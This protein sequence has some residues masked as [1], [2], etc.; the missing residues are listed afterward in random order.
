MKMSV[1]SVWGSCL[2]LVPS[3]ANS[4]RINIKSDDL[5]S[6]LF[7]FGQFPGV[8]EKS[9]QY[10]LFYFQLEDGIQ[11]LEA[12]LYT[13]DKINKDNSILPGIKL[14]LLAFDS[15]DD[16]HYSLEQSLDF[17]KGNKCFLLST[18]KDKDLEF[19]HF[20]LQGCF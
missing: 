15:C 10:F 17:V 2:V 4:L 11:P 14:G 20:D 16:V 5:Q 1:L 12:V 13:L 9:I 3:G 18:V 7:Y 19:S 6:D 8:D